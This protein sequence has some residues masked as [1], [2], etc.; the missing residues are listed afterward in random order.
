M[1]QSLGQILVVDD[2]T[3]VRMRM[4]EIVESIGY[5][6][7]EAGNGLEAIEQ[8]TAHP[9]IFMV[10]MDMNMPFMGGAET[11]ERLR[12]LPGFATT[13][14]CLMTTQ[15]NKKSIDAL[16]PFGIAAFIVK[17]VRDDLLIMVINELRGKQQK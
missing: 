2:S 17:P 11:V 14:I 9:D 3:T 10:F 8:A 7:L 4:R 16:R 12:S 6:I 13:P 1:E 15:T 5:E